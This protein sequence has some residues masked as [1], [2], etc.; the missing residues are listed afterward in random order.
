MVLVMHIQMYIANNGTIDAT[1]GDGAVTA[2]FASQV[3]AAGDFRAPTFYDLDNTA[4]YLNPGGDTSINT[5]GAWR[6]AS[7]TWD[8]EFA[9]KI[10][11]HSNWW[12]MQ[13]ANGVFIRNSSG[14]NNITLNSNGTGT[15]A[16]DVIAFSDKKLKT[17]IKTLDGTKVLKMRGV[18]FDR[19][20]ND[21]TGSGVIAQEL[22]EIAPEL[23]SDTKGTLGVAYGNLTG[24]LIEAIKNQ[25]K[26][27]DELK[28]Q[29]QTMKNN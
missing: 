19:I 12:Y 14:S 10:Q 5:K 7:S 15:F 23:V 25:Q 1:I 20:D 13:T 21:N 26:Q 28:T 29:I 8:G 2:W 6:C 18:S 9:G 22:Q 4:Y 17:N 3:H 11:Y 27:I 16:G 24:Y